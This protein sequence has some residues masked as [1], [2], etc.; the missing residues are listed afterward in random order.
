MNVLT[1]D[2]LGIETL[3]PREVMAPEPQ[4]SSLRPHNVQLM[5]TIRQVTFIRDRFCTK[6]EDPRTG[7]RILS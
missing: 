7:R 1:A 2:D 3:E 5:L 4:Q 6:L